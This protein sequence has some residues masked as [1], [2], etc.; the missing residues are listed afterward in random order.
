VTA[1]ELTKAVAE[2]E[3]HEPVTTKDCEAIFEE[4]KPRLPAG[5]HLDV[6]IRGYGSAMDPAPK[7]VD[8]TVRGVVEITRSIAVQS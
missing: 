1:A 4:I 2:Y 8:V 6:V 3:L 5:A 7:R